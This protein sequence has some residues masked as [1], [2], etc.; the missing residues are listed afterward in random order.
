MKKFRTLYMKDNLI[1]GHLL[2]ISLLQNFKV[3]KVNMIMD[4]YGLQMHQFM[5]WIQT[6]QLKTLWTNI[7]HMIIIN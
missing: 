3:M 5:V 6:M 7:Y 2:K 1:F 4:F